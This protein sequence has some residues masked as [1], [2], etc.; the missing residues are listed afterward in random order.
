MEEPG[1]GRFAFPFNDKDTDES[2]QVDAGSST[3]IFSLLLLLEEC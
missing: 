2:L 1:Y 3:L